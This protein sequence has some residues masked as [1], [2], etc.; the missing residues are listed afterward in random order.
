MKKQK[1]LS[2]VFILLL[3]VT[4][5]NNTDYSNSAPFDNGVYLSVAES[6]MSEA[7]T[8][9]KT[10]IQRNMEFTAR[11]AYPANTD[12]TV[13]ISVDP[14]QVAVYNSRNN[15]NYDALPAKYYRL[16]SNSTTI[17]SGKI[18]STPIHIYF[19][20]LTELEID[21]AYVCPVTL[22]SAQGVGLLEGSSTYWYIV[23]RSS[24]IT[25]AVDLQYCYVEVPGFYVPKGGTEP[26]GNAAHLNGMKAIT[27]EIITRINKFDTNTDISSLM[28]IEQLFCFRVG[29]AS[30][31]REQ[32]QIQTPA[33]KFPEANKAKLLKENEWY[34][35]AVTYDIAAKTIIFYVNGKE[36]SR[37][38]N[39]S[40][41]KF[42][43]INLADREQES[44]PGAS[45]GNTHLFYIGRSYNDLWLI[46][47]QLNGNVCEARIWDVA[48][49]Q[50]EIWA[51]MYDIENP[52]NEAHLA[53]YWKF[54]EGSGNDIKDYSKYHND[55][56]IV[57]YWKD[58]NTKEE[59]DVK[60]EV[61]WPGG[62]EVPQVN[63]EN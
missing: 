48:R 8:F 1:I 23:K 38:T 32:L 10:I 13:S 51:N 62:I 30:F 15:T 2:T 36:Q 45:D 40:N 41:S 33:G 44:S 3:T 63:K 43:E 50:Q 57:R 4:A 34:H 14:A 20:N 21:K 58:F 24:A 26:R 61:L 56:R 42:S 49:T 46:D 47:R 54:N 31:P 60:N 53:A 19:D 59:Y 35:L 28:G 27:F 11:L 12:V 18:N 39:Y 6:K 9:N 29:D 25:T 37:N 7:V 17:R 5:C 22:T 55:A 16:E 52:E